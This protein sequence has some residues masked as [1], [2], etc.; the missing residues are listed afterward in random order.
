M[1]AAIFLVNKGVLYIFGEVVTHLW[2]S[3]LS[4]TLR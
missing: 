4:Q 1:F 3:F 2:V